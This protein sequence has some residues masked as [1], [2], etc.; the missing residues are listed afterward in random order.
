MGYNAAIQVLKQAEDLKPKVL[1]KC[2]LLNDAEAWTNQQKLQNIYHQVLVLDL[3]YALDKKVEQD[4]WNIGFK[5]HITELQE[6]ARDKKNSRRADVQSLLTW[7]LESA[8]GFYLTLL[9][10]LCNTFDIDLPF[11]KRGLIYGQQTTCNDQ[12]IIPQTASCSYICQYCLVHLGDLARYRNQRKEAESF[13][14]QAI[15][16][17]PNSGHPY[18]QL[19]LLEASQGNKLSTVFYYIRGICVKNPFPASTTN[20]TNVLTAAIDKECPLEKIQTKMTVSEYIQLFISTHGH[21]HMLSDL[22]QAELSVKS[23]NSVMTALVAT[24]SFKKQEL[25]EITIINMYALGHLGN[26]DEELT[27]D[28]LKVKDL[29]LEL[30]AGTLSAF[31]MPVYTLQSDDG[32]L[33][34]YALPAVK[35]LMYFLSNK[36]NI[37]KCRVFKDRM[38]IWPSLCKLVNAAQGLLIGFNY[39][40]FSKCSLHEDRYLQGFLPL[41]QNIK[42]FNFKH[43]IQDTEVESK[44]RMRRIVDFAKWLADYDLKG[45]KLITK[46]ENK[47]EIVFEPVLSQPD[48]TNNLLE[49]MKSLSINDAVGSLEKK[50]GILKPQGSL[51]KAR[52]E[53]EVKKNTET[54]TE[55]LQK[56]SESIRSKRAKQNVVLQSIFKKIEEN[57]QVKFNVE[58]THDKEKAVKFDQASAAPKLAT[59]QQQSSASS[60][61][62]QPPN[63]F[64]NNPQPIRSQNFSQNTQT[65]PLSSTLPTLQQNAPPSND[66]LTNLRNIGKGADSMMPQFSKNGPF[67]GLPQNSAGTNQASNPQ[68]MK[69]PIFPPPLNVPPPQFSAWGRDDLKL[70]QGNNQGGWWGQNMTHQNQAYQQYPNQGQNLYGQQRQDSNLP[71]LPPS[72]FTNPS[73]SSYPQ[74]NQNFSAQRPQNPQSSQ[75]YGAMAFSQFGVQYQNQMMKPPNVAASGGLYDL[76]GSP[77]GMNRGGNFIGED[78]GQNS[79]SI[80]QAMLKE[81]TTVPGGRMGQ[82]NIPQTQEILPQ[83]PGYSLFNNTSWPPSISTQMRSNQIAENATFNGPQHSLFGGPGPQSL[84]QLLEHQQNQLGTSIRNSNNNQDT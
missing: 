52:E 74:Q 72:T 16:V 40:K 38:Q 56:S 11:R 66:Y 26:K 83:S 23:L 51:E 60:K 33:D 21:F 35:L 80:R 67:S 71:T 22:K 63:Q 31:L 1:Q 41:H 76:F 18:N 24:Q 57:K 49:E 37:F 7:S 6:K 79:M 65:F 34:Y 59:Q 50:V 44:V 42:G 81:A 70:P 4:L 32:L 25:L 13:Y 73:Q 75:A 58:E 69:M 47:G 12:I 30:I 78:G 29:I 68:S 77:W 62:P 45:P 9:Q 43:E 3:E 28:E 20:L 46:T 84:A 48:P 39:S 19:A 55:T 54:S 61:Q 53:R 27:K 8:S 64:N 14:K 17:S 82:Q 5:K 36:P 10:D 15:L 2:D